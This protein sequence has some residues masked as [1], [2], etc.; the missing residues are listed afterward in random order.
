MASKPPTKVW[1]VMTLSD[2][3]VEGPFRK[4]DA[5]DW[6]ACRCK[7][8]YPATVVGPYTLATEKESGAK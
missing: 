2:G 6:A 1:L 4:R 7:D 3:E 5:A 8:G